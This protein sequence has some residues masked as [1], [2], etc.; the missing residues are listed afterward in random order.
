MLWGL[1]AQAR[2]AIRLLREPQVPLLA[3][4][5]PLLAGL[6]LVSPIDAL[7]DIV[8]VLGQLDDISLIVA[9]L[10]LQPRTPAL[11]RGPR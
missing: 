7:P 8:P 4:A 6:Y 5:I 9:A 10:A 2:L 1:R 11:H 3:K